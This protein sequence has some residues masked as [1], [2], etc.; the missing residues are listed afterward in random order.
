MRGRGGG[1][2]FQTKGATNSYI[3]FPWGVFTRTVFSYAHDCDVHY[4][5]VCESKLVRD[6]MSVAKMFLFLLLGNS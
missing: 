6:R 3:I 4:L 2:V 1:K 5:C